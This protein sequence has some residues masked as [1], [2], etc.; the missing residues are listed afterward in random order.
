MNGLSAFGAGFAQGLEDK[1]RR[2]IEDEE[3]ARIQQA[4]EEDRAM[5]LEDRKMYRSDRAED[6]Q[7]REQQRVRAA[8]EEAKRAGLD[9]A[10]R[11]KLGMSPE[12]YSAQQMIEADK[13]ALEDRKYQR[14]RQ[15]RADR[16]ADS[17][18]SRQ[19]AEYNRMLK[20]RKTQDQ[21][22]AWA[23]D[24]T[25]VMPDGTIDAERLFAAYNDSDVVDPGSK[26]NLLADREEGLYLASQI[27]KDGDGIPD[28]AFIPREKVQ[29]FLRNMV[30]PGY[31]EQTLAAQQAQALAEQQRVQGLTDKAALSLIKPDQYGQGGA[32]PEQREAIISGSGLTGAVGKSL[33][34]GAGGGQGGRTIVRTGVD[35]DTGRKVAEYSDGSVGYID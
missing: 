4:Q 25:I 27:D 26:V 12:E 16:R 9:E 22:K 10:V 1:R 35:P 15:D 33:A 28:T 29:M 6:R 11:K 24:P 34:V 23:S 5:R 17:A 20:D 31:M 21:F 2:Q 32:S 3:R 14:T 8:A 7:W 13:F 19:E 30:Q 18:F